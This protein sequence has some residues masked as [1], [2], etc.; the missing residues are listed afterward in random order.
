MHTETAPLLSLALLFDQAA[1]FA[2]QAPL[3]FAL[4]GFAYL[5]IAYLGADVGLTNAW[6]NVS[7][8]LVAFLLSG[9]V[10]AYDTVKLA[11]VALTLGGLYL[12]NGGSVKFT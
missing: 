9:D 3:K 7:S 10:L 2:A 12:L 1:L 5:T 11:G 8:T 4:G 6:W